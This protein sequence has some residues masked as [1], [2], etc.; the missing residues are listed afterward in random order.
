MNWRAILRNQ[1]FQL[2]LV[3]ALFSA[4]TGLFDL[5]TMPGK[6]PTP[7]PAPFPTPTPINNRPQVTPAPAPAFVQLHAKKAG[8]WIVDASGGAD[9]DSR[10]LAQAVDSANGGDTITI[11]PGSYEVALAIQK[12]LVLVGEG[13]APANPLI[14]FNQDQRNVIN[15][16]GGHVTLSN[17]RIEHNI[18][19]NFAALYCGKQC[20]VELTNC[21]VF[22]KATYT[23]SA[24]D[25]AQLDVRTSLIG[26][27]EIGYGIYYFG[28][29][30]GS[31]TGSNVVGNKF[32][33][34]VQNESHVTA[35]DCT[36]QANGDQNGYGTVIDVSGSGATLEVSG[37]HFLQNVAG[38]YAQESGKLTMV[39]CNLENNGISLEGNHVTGGLICV[40]TAGQ[41]TLTNLICKSNKQGISVWP[42]GKAQ[43]NNVSLS[44]TGVVTNN[45][46]YRVYC[47]T[48]YVTGD[49]ANASLSGCTIV[50]A[51]YNGMFVMN[52]AKAS[53][54]NSSI[55][56]CKFYGLAFGSDEGTPG[57]G[58]VTNSKIFGN[59]LC[60]ILAQSKSSIEVS[61]GEITDNVVNGI[62]VN[63]SVV[64]LTNLFVRNQGQVGI[65]GYSG[66]SVMAKRCTIEKNRIGLQA[67]LPNKGPES[68]GTITLESSLVQD[69]S[70]YGAISGAGSTIS[71]N[72]NR[73]RNGRNDFLREAGGLIQK[74]GN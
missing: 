30:R 66:G 28:R 71:L 27:S 3:A 36:F 67:G 39:S 45:A 42:A 54:E 32:G 73:F 62:E 43:L 63:A 18:N 25:D 69:N 48:I 15:I 60:G 51:E 72:G 64:T 70:G 35:N 34:E 1:W 44:G 29:S 21:S 24:G 46:Q 53:V 50:D 74:I 61:G 13:I 17:L 10:N 23:V 26:S 55:S 40:E 5:A 59:H 52:G 9:A 11:R 7:T 14:F 37:S 31:V 20:Q 38:V 22:S 58:T 4:G 12:D 41:A 16:S 57:S 56:N 6:N 49:G 8:H 47:N 65:I 33:L 19:N 2:C 68:G